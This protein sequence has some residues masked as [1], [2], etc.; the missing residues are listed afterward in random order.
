M[1]ILSWNINGLRA[2]VK[3]GMM[4]FLDESSADVCCVQET[5]ATVDQVPV[6]VRESTIW[7]FNLFAAD[8]DYKKG[9]SGVG[10]FSRKQPDELQT[11]VLGDEFDQEGRF[12]VARFGA[13]FIASIYFPNGSGP[14]RSNSR[15]E[16][17]LRFY[18]AAEEVLLDLAK[19]GPVLVTGDFNTA[20]KAIDLARPKTN[21]ATSGFL[22]IERRE[23]DRWLANGWVDSFR[24]FH[25]DEPEHYTWWRQWGGAREQNVGWRIDYVM[26]SPKA[27]EFL[28]DAFILP[29][30]VGSDHCPIGIDLD[31][32]RLGR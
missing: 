2:C 8:P 16:Y 28:E 12:L 26:T 6:E 21:E 13:L 29:D 24:R 7:N 23:L 32:K 1:R 15:V 4:N 14:N 31:D 11:N 20:H 5:R 10:I 9:Y 30:V 18:Q 25:P 3:K 19:S 27:T 22:P 17:K